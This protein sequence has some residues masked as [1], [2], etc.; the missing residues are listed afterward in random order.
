MNVDKEVLKNHSEQLVG[1]DF[2]ELISF[3]KVRMPVKIVRVV[4]SITGK[5]VQ[6]VISVV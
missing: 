1:V 2:V 6:V 5:G 4:I 3:V